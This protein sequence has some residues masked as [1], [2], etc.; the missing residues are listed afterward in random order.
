MINQPTSGDGATEDEI[1]KYTFMLI[2]PSL[3]VEDKINKVR[4]E[5]S[6]DI[7]RRFIL[8]F[9]IFALGMMLAISLCLN[10]ISNQITEP[11]IE[12]Y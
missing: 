2:I 10:Y 7:F 3:V 6:N 1:K 8:P 9:A 12:L 5:V 4:D 11:I